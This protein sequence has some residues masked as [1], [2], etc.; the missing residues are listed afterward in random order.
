MKRCASAEPDSLQLATS[1]AWAATA[2]APRR[3]GQSA[4][5]RRPQQRDQKPRRVGDRCPGAGRLGWRCVIGPHLARRAR[6]RCAQL[7]GRCRS[8]CRPL[9]GGCSSRPRSRCDRLPGPPGHCVSAGH[10]SGCGGSIARRRCDNSSRKELRSAS[11]RASAS[12]TVS[13]SK[14]S[15]LASP[16]G[17][18]TGF[19]L[20]PLRQLRVLVA[21]AGR[22]CPQDAEATHADLRVNTNRRMRGTL[23]HFD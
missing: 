22:S 23:A 6:C 19:I 9:V 16:P 10:R 14:A 8:W 5:S 3:T 2:S 13:V 15:S 11:V 18:A 12:I 7:S 1:P 21:A 4:F 17:R 20:S